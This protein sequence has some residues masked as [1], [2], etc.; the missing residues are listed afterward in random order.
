MD[1][2]VTVHNALTG[3][4]DTCPDFPKPGYEWI[5]QGI[6]LFFKEWKRIYSSYTKSPICVKSLFLYHTVWA[7]VLF[8]FLKRNKSRSTVYVL[9]VYDWQKIFNLGIKIRILVNIYLMIK[10]W[11]R[12]NKEVF[13]IKLVDTYDSIA[14]IL[15]NRNNKIW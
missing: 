9:G 8:F 2:T 11:E 6:G 10:N 13:I 7:G 15:I 14:F 3:N 1:D 4:T 5:C 12:K